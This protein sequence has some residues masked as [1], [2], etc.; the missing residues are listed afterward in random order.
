MFFNY[1]ECEELLKFLTITTT[2]QNIVVYIPAKRCV[3][4]AFFVLSPIHFQQRVPAEFIDSSLVPQDFSVFRLLASFRNSLKG[5][6]NYVPLLIAFFYFLGIR[7]IPRVRKSMPVFVEKGQ[8]PHPLNPVKSKQ[9]T[10]SSTSVC[11]K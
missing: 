3:E 4:F 5:F 10:D 2:K 11:S 6:A 7:G 1:A 8:P 9:K